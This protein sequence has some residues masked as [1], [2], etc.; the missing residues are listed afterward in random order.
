MGPITSMPGYT[1]FVRKLQRFNRQGLDDISKKLYSHFNYSD[2]EVNDVITEK[3]RNLNDD[4]L[5]IKII[6]SLANQIHTPS[7]NVGIIADKI[8]L[9]VQGFRTFKSMT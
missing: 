7:S 3:N 8:N 5:K 2:D 4:T 1:R 9:F 6:H